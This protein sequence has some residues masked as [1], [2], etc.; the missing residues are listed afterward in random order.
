MLRVTSRSVTDLVNGHVRRVKEFEV[1]D[2]FPFGVAFSWEKDGEPTTSTLFEKHGPIPSA[3]MLT[4][5]R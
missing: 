2:S 4:F 5:Y 1:I 3:K